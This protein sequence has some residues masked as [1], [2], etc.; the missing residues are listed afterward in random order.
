[1]RAPEQPSGW[2]RAMAPPSGFTRSGSMP[3]WS[4]QASAWAAGSDT[5][6]NI[7]AILQKRRTDLTEDD[8]RVMEEVVDAVAEETDPENEP[9]AGHTARRHRL[10][11][12][13]HDPLKA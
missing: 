12:L 5:D 6:S 9:V 10:M 11:T 1:M 2:P 3:S 4:T 8:L 13:G 7:L